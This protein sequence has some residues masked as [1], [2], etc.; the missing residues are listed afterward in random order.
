MIFTKQYLIHLLFTL[1]LAGQSWLYA[2]PAETTVA[3]TNTDTGIQLPAGFSATV[4]A[5]DLGRARHITVRDDGV[6]YVALLNKKRGSGIVA[7]QD[8]TG[9][10]IADEIVYFGDVEGTGIGL[11][12]NHLYFGTNT[13]VVRWAFNEDD[14]LVPSGNMETVISDFLKQ[15][16]HA[17]KPFTFDQQGHIYV[18]V[19]APSNACQKMTRTPGSPGLSPCPQLDLQAGIWQFDANKLGQQH[20]K[21]G[22]RYATGVRNAMAL[23]WHPVAEQ[24]LIAPHDRDDLHRLFPKYYTVEQNA[25][26]PD[27]AI[28]RVEPGDNMGWPTSYWDSQLNARMLAPEYG[29]NGEKRVNNPRFKKPMAA[30]PGHWAP[31]GMVVYTG[32]AFPESYQGGLFIAY[33]GS[34]NRAPLPQAGYNVAFFPLNNK[35]LPD[36]DWFVFADGF[37]GQRVI[38]SPGEARYRPVGLAVANDGAMYI[39]DS[40]KGRIW[41]VTYQ[42]TEDGGQ[43]AE[44]RREQ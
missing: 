14:T 21:D 15:R 29:G 17:A 31:N 22:K 20:G 44:D 3:L 23:A 16:Q 38:Q 30:V 28:F 4:F 13:K 33:H 1:C 42:R 40:V 25:E 5:D 12:D 2:M 6:V 32:D 19:G 41:R 36:G 7:L 26:L 24:L 37:K 8:S 34:W 11:H 10:G 18:N 9:D 43:R 35:A 27:E 39:A